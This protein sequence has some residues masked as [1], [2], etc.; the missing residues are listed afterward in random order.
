M[1]YVV[2]YFDVNQATR[3]RIVSVDENSGLSEDALRGVLAG[4]ISDGE[5]RHR[6]VGMIKR[7]FPVIAERTIEDPANE[8]EFEEDRDAE[9]PEPMGEEI[10]F[11]EDRNET[12]S[13]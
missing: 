12:Q 7:V 4:K 9:K 11:E 1:K 2:E 10:E 6:R 5:P 3:T 8:I 13:Q